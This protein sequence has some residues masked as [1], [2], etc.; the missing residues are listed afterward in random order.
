MAD[1]GDVESM[2]NYAL[3]ILLHDNRLNQFKEAAR[4]KAKQFDIH[5]I[6]PEY[7][8]L[9]KQ[10]ADNSLQGRLVIGK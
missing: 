3:D 4:A 6:I 9:Y 10:V 5:N 2:A 8:T 1:V 7:E